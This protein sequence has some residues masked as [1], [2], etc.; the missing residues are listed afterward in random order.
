MYKTYICNGV[1]YRLKNC[2][3]VTLYVLVHLYDNTCNEKKMFCRV[4]SIDCG[5]EVSDWLSK[6]LGRPGCRL[7]RQKAEDSRKSKLKQS[8]RWYLG[9]L[10]VYK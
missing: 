6:V 5:Q 4:Q 1:K 2:R 3:D 8:G 7:I 9:N 10:Y